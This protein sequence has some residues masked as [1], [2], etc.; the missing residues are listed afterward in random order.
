VKTSFVL[1]LRPFGLR[2][3]TCHRCG[4][5]S[6]GMGFR[7]HQKYSNDNN[8]VIQ[9][10]FFKFIQIGLICIMM[11]TADLN[12]IVADRMSG[13]HRSRFPPDGHSE[14]P[15]RINDHPSGNQTTLSR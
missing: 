12:F 8:H 11:S 9:L 4:H 6:A 15:G 2:R 3:G 14:L 1:R 13:V 7:F 10:F 5:L